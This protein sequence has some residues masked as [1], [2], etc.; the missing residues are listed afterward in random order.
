MEAVVGP[1]ATDGS[2]AAVP[3]VLNSRLIKFVTPSQMGPG[4]LTRLV[5]LHSRSSLFDDADLVRS[6]LPDT[7][8][9]TIFGS[10]EEAK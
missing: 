2:R 8:D 9:D 5:R 4:T 3:A 1:A 10:A 7:N 6:A